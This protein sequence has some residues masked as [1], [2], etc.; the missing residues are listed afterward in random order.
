MSTKAFCLGDDIHTTRVDTD[1]FPKFS[2]LNEFASLNIM[3][4]KPQVKP[5]I[6]FTFACL[7]A[8]IIASP[9]QLCC[10]W[11]LNQNMLSGLGCFRS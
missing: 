9:S 2:A 7:A 6:N 4:N 3:R 11:F 8:A 5:T 10:D 1:D